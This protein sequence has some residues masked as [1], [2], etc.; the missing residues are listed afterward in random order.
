MNKVNV[1]ITLGD[2]ADIFLMIDQQV[3]EINQELIEIENGLPAHESYVEK[4]RNRKKS[5]LELQKKF[6][7]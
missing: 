6:D 1:E 4:L 2:A 5:F 3:L 7:L